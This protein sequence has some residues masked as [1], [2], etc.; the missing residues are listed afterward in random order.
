MWKYNI[1]IEEKKMQTKRKSIERSK[2]K[3]GTILDIEVVNRL[4]ERSAHEG[5]AISAI[6]EDAVLKYDTEDILE[7]EIRLKA[8]NQLFSLKF[9]I[10]D[11]TWEEI[12]E[13]DYFE[14]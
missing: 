10:P 13:E 6:I 7:R 2:I 9:N 1:L 8:M 11:E 4:K 3:I 14:Q 5:K 12:M